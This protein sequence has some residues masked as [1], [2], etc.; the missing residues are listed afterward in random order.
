MHKIQ[1]VPVYIGLGSNQGNPE[2]NL[3]QARAKVQSMTGV[4]AA[5]SS[6]IYYTE[7]QGVKDQPWFA[8]QVL[9][10]LC[11]PAWTPPS[12][13]RHLLSIEKLLGRKR[14][15]Y[16][17]PRRIDCDLLLFGQQCISQPK[18]VLPHPRM[19]HRAF[20]LVPLL[21]VS[22]ELCLPDGTRVRESLQNLVYRRQGRRI[23]QEDDADQSIESLKMPSVQQDMAS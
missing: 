10:I 12:F 2:E 23:W 21:E 13:M 1:M 4:F 9:K 11:H 19:I 16:W 8:N 7:P 3:A 6:Q 15:I 5:V 22:P 17:G 18:L 14:D 20:V